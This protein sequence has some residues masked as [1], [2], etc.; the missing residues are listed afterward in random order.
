MVITLIVTGAIWALLSQGQNAFRREPEVSDRQQQIRVAMDLIQRDLVTAGMSLPEF[1]QAF[2]IDLDGV[3][4]ANAQGVASDRLELIGYDGACLPVTLCDTPLPPMGSPVV[5]KDPLPDCYRLLPPSPTPPCTG[6]GC[7][8][9]AVRPGVGGGA[10][11]TI[12]TVTSAAPDSACTALGSHFELASLVR[13][14]PGPSNVLGAND[15]K[16][17][18]IVRYEIAVDADG[19][20]SLWRSARGGLDAAGAPVAAPG[21]GSDWQLVAT[22][23]EDLQVEYRTGEGL[24]GPTLWQTGADLTPIPPTPTAADYDKIVR[25]VRVTLTARTTGQVTLSG[26]TQSVAGVRAIRGNLTSVTAPRAALFA[27]SVGPPA[28]DPQA[29]Q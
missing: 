27:L 13:T 28:G 8:L 24:P 22:G 29:W 18:Q 2:T 7:P 4:P 6:A 25:E 10:A 9:V 3:G 15:V 1:V 19:I 21:A 14:I 23:I 17:I 20:P 11:A 12:H 5:V 26:E 16:P